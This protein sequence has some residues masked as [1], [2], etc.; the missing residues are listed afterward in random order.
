MLLR[1]FNTLISGARRGATL[2]EEFPDETLRKLRRAHERAPLDQHL[3]IVLRG[4][5]VGDHGLKALVDRCAAESGV[6]VVPLK[7]LHRPFASYVLAQYFLHALNVE[8]EHAECGV[9]AGTSALVM[10]RAAQTCRP[11]YAGEGLHLIDSFAGLGEP[12]REDYVEVRAGD[13]AE[14]RP[15]FPK[16]A[17]AAPVEVVRHAMRDFPA[18]QIH[19]GWIPDVFTALPEARWALVHIDVDQAAPTR[20]CLDYFYPRLSAG[21]VIVCD[22]YGAPLFPGA[23]R[24]WDAFCEE[25]DVPYVALDTGQSVILKT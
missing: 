3:D 14:L 5:R 6:Q 7:M 13:S 16:G 23:A 25:H 21:G 4:M 15:G 12:T 10:C 1:F 17:L 8:G 18:V 24:A 22:D 19:K 20:A 9:F 11:G 2:P